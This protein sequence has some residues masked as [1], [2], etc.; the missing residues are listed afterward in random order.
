MNINDFINKFLEKLGQPDSMDAL[1]EYLYFIES[2][3]GN[4]Y[5]ETEY[6][7]RHHILPQYKFK[8]YRFSEWNIIKLLY[9]DHVKAHELLYL[10]YTNR[11]IGRTLNFMKS[12]LTKDSTLT[13]IS[14]K[15]GWA[16]LKSNPE[17]YTQWRTRRS[18]YM[19]SVP[20]EIFK[21]QQL[22]YWSN[23]SQAEYEKRCL[24]NKLSWTPERRSSQSEKLSNYFKNNPDEIAYRNKKRWDNMP[25]NKRQAF[26]EK[27][28]I[29]NKDINKRQK[30]GEKIR[31]KW[32]DPIFLEKMKNKKNYEIELELI[33]PN[34]EV[35]TRSGF[36]KV[37]NEFKFSPHILKKFLDTDTPATYLGIKQE[38]INTIGW[39]FT[40]TNKKWKRHGKTNES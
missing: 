14:S 10:A 23:I 36:W 29:I 20:S 39:R 1:Y 4:I 31:N 2:K 7:E 11:S 24:G 25:Q 16:K 40:Q 26:N 12:N 34:G 9:P 27:M 17:K 18:V 8:E 33:S 28:T 32:K 38:G 19:K 37:I 6:C 13:S 21:K 30:A 3:L 15:K 22:N 5:S 35:F